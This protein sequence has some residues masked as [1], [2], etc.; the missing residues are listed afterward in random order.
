MCNS[1]QVLLVTPFYKPNVGG[2]ETFAEDLAKQLSKKYVVHI[3]TIKWDKPILWQGM[4]FKKSIT[5]IWKLLFPLFRMT[6]R[7]KYEK[8]YALGLIP[9][10][11]CVCLRLKFN[12][13]LLCLYNFTK[14][15]I[16]TKLINRAE[17]VFVEG[18]NGKDDLIRIGVIKDKIISFQH[19][20]DQTRFTWL[21]RNNERLK[22]LFVGRPIRVKGKHIIQQC[23]RMTTGIDYEY[24]ENVKYEDLPKHYQMADVVVVPSLYTESYTRVVVESASCGCA[25]IVSNMGSL[26]EQV[27]GFGKVIEPTPE[28]FRDLLVKLRDNR[29]ALERLRLSTFVYAK[30]HFSEANADCF[31]C[32]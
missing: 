19:W 26:P 30:K 29:N 15:N 28:N 12:T 8:I 27:E 6:R 14:P 17:R 24:I 2:A 13:I 31:L 23:E 25:V 22:V 32:S 4:D 11:L 16:F 21:E 5:L 3:C 7:Y 18:K 1:G 20:C 9:T 10:F